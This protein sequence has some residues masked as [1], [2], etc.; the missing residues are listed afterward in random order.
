M[1]TVASL[2]ERNLEF[3]YLVFRE[4]LERCFGGG[5]AGREVH[6]DEQLVQRRWPGSGSGP[7]ETRAIPVEGF[8]HRAAQVLLGHRFGQAVNRH[9]ARGVD[10]LA[11]LREIH[12]WLRNHDAV[13]V[14]AEDDSVDVDQ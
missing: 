8:G 5:N 4:L 6:L 1:A 7:L 12:L 9:N 2:D 11:F 10:W 3:Q 13:A 14:G